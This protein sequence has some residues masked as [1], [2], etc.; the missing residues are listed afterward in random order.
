MWK[1]IQ[2]LREERGESRSDLAAALGVTLDELTNWE[3]GRIRSIC[4]HIA[5]RPLVSS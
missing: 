3:L 1:T 4:S 2:E 5:T